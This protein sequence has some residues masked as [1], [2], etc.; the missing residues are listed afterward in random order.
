MKNDDLDIYYDV[1]VGQHDLYRRGFEALGKRA[2]VDSNVYRKF[3]LV[4]KLASELG[5]QT[6][7][8][9]IRLLRLFKIEKFLSDQNKGDNAK[10]SNLQLDLIEK[11]GFEALGKRK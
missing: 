11:R 3:R 9:R 2:N 7:E 5:Y 1:L 6:I 4:N 10:N 8:D